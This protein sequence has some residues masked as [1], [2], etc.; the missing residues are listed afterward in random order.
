MLARQEPGAPSRSQPIGKRSSERRIPPRYFHGWTIVGCAFCIAVFGWGLGFY[1]PGLYIARL[2][3][4]HGWP[5]ATLSAAVTL[6]YVASGSFVIFIGDVMERFGP[7]CVVLCGSTALASGVIAL[8][9]VEAV[10]QMFA[11]FLLM[12]AGCAAT[13]GAAIQAIVAP[14]FEKR[15]GLA[16]SLALN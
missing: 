16:T 8:T 2:N 11:A 4:L 1:G 7:R 12:S 13:T 6:Y 9:R 10:W 14:W 3:A 5:I 15:R